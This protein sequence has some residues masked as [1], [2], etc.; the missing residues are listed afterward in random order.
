MSGFDSVL[1]PSEAGLQ[2]H[3]CGIYLLVY[4]Y[5]WKESKQCIVRLVYSNKC[6]FLLTDVNTHN[7]RCLAIFTKSY[8]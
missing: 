4:A 7:Y 8:S 1:V 3:A 2:M 5:C 6:I